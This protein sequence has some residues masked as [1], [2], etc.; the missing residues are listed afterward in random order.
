[1]ELNLLTKFQ[2]RMVRCLG[3]E[4][5]QKGSKFPLVFMAQ[6]LCY[7]YLEGKNKSQHPSRLSLLWTRNPKN[8]HVYILEMS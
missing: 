7:K 1:M 3:Q 4:K 5:E 8:H 6:G 2:A